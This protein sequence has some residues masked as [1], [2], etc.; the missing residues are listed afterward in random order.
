[1]RRLS[2]FAAT[3]LAAAVLATPVSAGE[4]VSLFNGKDL[5][6]WSLSLIHI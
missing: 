1:M 4:A 2:C 6:G 3:I 5:T